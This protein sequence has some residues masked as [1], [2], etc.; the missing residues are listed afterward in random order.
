[1]LLRGLLF[2][3]ALVAGVATSTGVILI[4]PDTLANR[5]SEGETLALAPISLG[6]PTAAATLTTR[7]RETPTDGDPGAVTAL[8]DLKVP[9]RVGRGD[10]L[11]GMLTGAGVS[12]ADA[13]GAIS[14]LSKHFNPRRIK[15]GQTV[16]VLFAPPAVGS[17]EANRPEPGKFLGLVVEPD[18]DTAIRVEKTAE[19]AFSAAKI[20]KSLTQA[21]ARAG[22]VIRTSLYV[23]GRKAG[24]P[25]RV[26]AELIRAY[27]WDIDFQRDIRAGDR[28]EVMYERFFDGQGDGKRRLVYSGPILYAALTLS[29]KRHPIYLHA[30]RDGD[31]DYYDDKGQSARKALMRTPIDGARLSSG[32]GRRRHPILGYTK[33]H[34]GVDFAAPRGTPIY[35]AGNGV[36][37]RSGRNGAYGKYIR[38]RHNSRYSTAYAHMRAIDRSARRGKRVKQGQIIGTVGSTGRSTGPHLHYEILAG[39]VRTNPMKVKMPPGRKLK[40]EELED[41]QVARAVIDGKFAAFEPKAKV[42]AAGK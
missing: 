28:F 35:A 36:V 14:A 38:I 5:D 17:P 39:G 15:R 3:A 19:G 2:A 7:R 26:L 11:A 16:A 42:A 37:V 27:S 12:P 4:D 13:R 30:T 32:F 8:P 23:A 22:G 18:Y 41:F 31:S 40:G 10:T 1:M 34:R 29:G 25:R 33:L 9:L 20:K 21:P 24:I 6:N